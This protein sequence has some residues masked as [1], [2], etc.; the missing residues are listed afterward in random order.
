MN[1][2]TY[3]LCEALAD[4]SLMVGHD[5]ATNSIRRPPDSRELIRQLIE[6]AD[7]FERTNA[8]RE[9]DGEYM[10]AIGE[11]YQAKIRELV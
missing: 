7:E 10:E 11:F 8:G 5:L 6:W 4:L 9:W 1:E 2:R 3:S